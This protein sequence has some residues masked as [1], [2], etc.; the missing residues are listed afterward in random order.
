MIRV[1]IAASTEI[2]A[3]AGADLANASGNMVDA[4]LVVALVQHHFVAVSAFSLS[5]RR[6]HAFVQ[7][8][9]EASITEYAPPLP[10]SQF[11][12]HVKSL[13]MHQ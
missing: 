9:V 2:S 6:S 7:N 10:A 8:I 1:A 4:V 5:I 3:Q 13:K 11:G 12:Y